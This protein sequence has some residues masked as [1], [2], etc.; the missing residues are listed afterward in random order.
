MSSETQNFITIEDEEEVISELL[1]SLEESEEEADGDEERGWKDAA[2][3]LIKASGTKVPSR[4]KRGLVWDSDLSSYE[5]GK[6]E[7]EYWSFGSDID[8]VRLFAESTTFARFT[9]ATDTDWEEQTE[10]R[11][12]HGAEV[13]QA[14]ATDIFDTEED[15]QVVYWMNEDKQW[16]TNAAGELPAFE[17]LESVF[18]SDHE[19]SVNNAK[20]FVVNHAQELLRLMGDAQQLIPFMVTAFS[21]ANGSMS[22]IDAV[23]TFESNFERAD[24][25][26]AL[27]DTGDDLT[28]VPTSWLVHLL[29]TSE[30]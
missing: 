6:L 27:G 16:F 22:E 26:K 29:M 15:G 7:I 20:L 23:G 5:P 10:V 28:D 13:W 21:G 4:K 2:V 12:E 24:L 30:A 1:Q 11:W 25:I 8:F 14:T 17:A 3:K 9:F 18:S 19:F